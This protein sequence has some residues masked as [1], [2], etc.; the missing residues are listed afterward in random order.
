MVDITAG[1]ISLKVYEVS[2][3]NRTATLLT[4]KAVAD[5]TATDLFTTLA[6]A[7]SMR[8]NFG[9]D[10]LVRLIATTDFADATTNYLE[11]NGFVE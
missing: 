10:L 4:S 8:S 3:D 11:V 6:S 7:G 1:T 5:N 9:N 2:P